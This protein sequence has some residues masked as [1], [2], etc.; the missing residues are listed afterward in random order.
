[1]IN[2][3]QIWAHAP[4]NLLPST[5]LNPDF[6][7]AQT[8]FHVENMVS[9]LVDATQTNDAGVLATMIT[10]GNGGSNLQNQN[11]GAAPGL[12]LPPFR[13]SEGTDE[14]VQLAPYERMSFTYDNVDTVNEFD[15]IQTAFLGHNDYT[16]AYS[17]QLIRRFLAL[18]PLVTVPAGGTVNQ[19]IFINPFNDDQAGVGYGM[20]VK[21]FVGIYP[22][23]SMLVIIRDEGSMYQLMNTPIFM[24]NF[25]YNFN[26]ENNFRPQP[27]SP[28][29]A[30]QRHQYTVS[31]L[32]TSDEDAPA[33]LGFYGNLCSWTVK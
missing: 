2:S 28:W 32:N 15:N 31:F 24:D 19:T 7:I 4:I 16:G 29:I 23:L 9:T 3:F 5:Q 27:F 18:T 21:A 22:S 8:L 25:V 11:I 13:N 33:Q 20:L 12:W 10:G 14:I 6:Q 17:V 26:A 30:P 1:M